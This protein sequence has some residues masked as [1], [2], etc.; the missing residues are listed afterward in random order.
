ME[1]NGLTPGKGEIVVNWGVYLKY[2]VWMKGILVT[3]AGWT[4]ERTWMETSVP[5]L[6]WEES[7]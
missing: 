4:L 6:R 1:I 2:F 7:M 5:D 3:V